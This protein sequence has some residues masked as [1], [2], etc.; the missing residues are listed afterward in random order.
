MAKAEKQSVELSEKEMDT[1]FTALTA[2][3]ELG[4]KVVK[5]AI[6]IKADNAAREGVKFQKEIEELKSKFLHE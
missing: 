3:Q 5:G 1:I 6:A 4:D 2:L